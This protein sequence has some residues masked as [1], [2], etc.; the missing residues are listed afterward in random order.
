MPEE[1]QVMP[2]DILILSKSMAV[3]PYGLHRFWNSFVRMTQ[4]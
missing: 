4:L 1:V 3:Q 2:F